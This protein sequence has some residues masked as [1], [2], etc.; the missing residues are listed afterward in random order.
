MNMY[1]IIGLLAIWLVYA[2]IIRFLGKKK[3]DYSIIVTFVFI[4]GF[5]YFYLYDQF[6]TEYYTY[7][8]YSTFGFYGLY[9]TVSN[10]RKHFRKSISEYDF[11]AIEKELEDVSN[12]SE[13][14]R[15]RF[16]S[17]IEL[18]HDGIAFRDQDELIYGSDKY[19]E[20][21]GI[22][23]NQFSFEEF[24]KRIYKD[25][26]P[27][28]KMV[29]E[30][31]SKRNP[32]YTIDYRVKNGSHIHWVKEIGKKINVEKKSSIISIVR[33]MDIKQFPQSEIDVLNT[34]PNQQKLY[35]E[36]QK[37]TRTKKAYHLVIIQLTNIPK[38][39]E[40]YGRDVGDLMMGEYLKKLQYNF[41][42]DSQSLFRIGGINYGL[43]IKDQKKFEF[44]E[45]ALQGAGELLNLNMVFGG[46]TQTLYPNLGI[47]EAPYEG[48]V[49]DRVLNEANEA[50]KISLKDSSNVN[51]CYFDRV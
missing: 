44:L 14:L 50:L 12:S 46:V 21:L 29:L 33:A 5:L 24:E 48:K 28:Y 38:I 6:E 11:Y 19:I 37:L 43:L 7:F 26:L 20:L 22:N 23:E 27:Q 15:K 47:A 1:L 9:M 31:L 30:K 40:K 2:L 45:R 51:Y 16:I 39:N 36:M 32:I 18:L 4:L 42:K 10:L 41:M 34:L 3:L 25:D 13:L 8:Y 17:T 49:P 35:D